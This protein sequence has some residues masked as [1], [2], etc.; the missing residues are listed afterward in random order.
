[1]FQTILRGSGLV[2]TRKKR[3]RT[4]SATK[5]FSAVFRT[6][7]AFLSLKIPVLSYL[8]KSEYLPSYFDGCCCG[9]VNS[10]FFT[11]FHY[12][13]I[14]ELLDGKF[15]PVDRDIAVCDNSSSSS[16]SSSSTD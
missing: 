4:F 12:D 10:C 11:I 13:Y 6:K 15:V 8:T 3:C 7:K 5:E 16:G 9:L 1:M 2:G 14:F